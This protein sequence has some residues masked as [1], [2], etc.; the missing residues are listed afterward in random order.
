MRKSVM[1]LLSTLLLT[2]AGQLSRADVSVGL[3][4][5]DDGLKAFHLAIGEHYQVPERQVVLVREKN[6]PEEELPVVFFLARRAD[7]DPSVIV[8][9]RL[10]GYSWMEITAKYG[11]SA[12]IYYVA[13]DRD[14]GPPY[15]NAWGHF[16]NRHRKEWGSIHLTDAEVVNFVNLKFMCEKYGYTPADVVKMRVRGDDF[17]KINKQVKA[18]KGKS[19]QK[20]DARADSDPP[21][22]KAKGKGNNK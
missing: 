2:A 18:G 20:P 14:P 22:A 10:G 13:F 17:V 8:K 4:V 7:V 9:L 15:G 21:K 12:E 11:L 16:K 3:S 5:D 1:I 19:A 6:V